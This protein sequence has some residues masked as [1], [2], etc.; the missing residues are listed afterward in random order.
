MIQK[1]IVGLF[2]LFLFSNSNTRC[3]VKCLIF[4]KIESNQ[5]ENKT[6]FFVARNEGALINL[7]SGALWPVTGCIRNRVSTIHLSL[8]RFTFSYSS[9]ASTRSIQ[10]CKIMAWRVHG[11]VCMET[12]FPRHPD[13]L[14]EQFH[15]HGHRWNGLLLE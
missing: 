2:Q 15:C 13:H 7:E 9:H 14:H 12:C 11:A 6:R 10:L 3:H 1:Q 8:C 4:T 5:K